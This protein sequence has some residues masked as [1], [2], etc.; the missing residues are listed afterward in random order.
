VSAANGLP[1]CL[2]SAFGFLNALAVSLDGFQW[3]ILG[4]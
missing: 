2:D 3:L 4:N 1:F